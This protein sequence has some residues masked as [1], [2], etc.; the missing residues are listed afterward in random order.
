MHFKYEKESSLESEIKL[1]SLCHESEHHMP[2]KLDL[3]KY[4]EYCK[5]MNLQKWFSVF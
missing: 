3:R 4:W 1:N 2:T 5:I